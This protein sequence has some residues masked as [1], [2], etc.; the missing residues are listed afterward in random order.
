M[1][2]VLIG[3]IALTGLGLMTQ[4]ALAADMARPAPRAAYPTKVPEARLFDWTGFYAGLNGG[5][6]WGDSKFTGAG[7]ANTSPEGAI[8]GGTIGYN[9]QWGQTVFGIESDIAWNDAKGSTACALGNCETKNNWLGTTR[10]RLGYAF[11]RLMPYVTGG[12]AYGDVKANVPGL[13]SAS[14]TQFGWTVGG[15]VEY[16][17]TPNWT[18]K[19]EYL[20]VDLGKL[21]CPACGGDVKFNENIVRGGVNY[22]F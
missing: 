20:Y 19:A 12:A 6:G 9:Y 22:K 17:F 21:N 15:G 10:L 1:K 16:A 4:A 18:V 5:Y 13:G 8:L 3:A 11:D 7:D 2:R 14:D